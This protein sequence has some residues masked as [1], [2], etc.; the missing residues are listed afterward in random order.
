MQLKPLLISLRR[1]HQTVL[2]IMTESKFASLAVAMKSPVNLSLLLLT[3]LVTFGGVMVMEVHGTAVFY[4]AMARQMVES[5]DLLAPFRGD[6]GYLLKPPLAFWWSAANTLVMGYSNLAVTLPSRL[7]GL[8]CAVMTALLAWHFHRKPF[9]VWVAVLLFV[10]NGIYI[11]FTTAF[12]LDSLMTFGA[13]LMLWG[14]LKLPRAIGAFALWSG[15]ALSLMTKGPMILVMLA[16]MLPHALLSPHWRGARANL[17]RY[18]PLLLL[19][20][21]WYGFIWIF[22]GE[23]LSRQLTQDFWRGDTSNLSRFDSVWL[24]YVTKP[25]YRLGPWLVLIFIALYQELRLAA[26][27]SVA[28]PQRA[29]AGLLLALVFLNTIIAV[30]KPDPDVRYFYSVLPLVAVMGGGVMARR[31]GAQVPRWAALLGAALLLAGAAGVA[32]FN[33]KAYPGHQGLQAIVA[34]AERGE[35]TPANT[36]LMV[37]RIPKPNEPRRNDP[38]PDAVYFYFGL[39]LPSALKLPTSGALP[40]STRFVL[41]P[42]TARMLNTVAPL[43]WPERARSEKFI[44]LER[45]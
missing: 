14:Y 44:L 6:T 24:E 33:V 13:L 37:E 9:A 34:L 25:F 11:Q 22:H 3:V 20:L 21:A 17:L 35:L 39:K 28:V 16:I 5:G 29:D 15:T 23:E 43:G 32:W 4:A 27:A 36:L 26:S 10:M 45:P 30:L 7:G 31:F 8:G 42:R 18:A 2:N 40:A 19:P 1:T 38:I 12:R 41:L